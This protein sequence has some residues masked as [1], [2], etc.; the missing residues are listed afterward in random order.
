MVELR[1]ERL[2]LRMWRESDLRPWV[3]MNADPAVREHLPEVGPREPDLDSF[4]RFQGLLEHRNGY[5]LWVV[6]PVGGPSFAGVVGMDE[7][8]NGMPYSGMEATLAPARSWSTTAP[9]TT[10]NAVPTR[11]SPTVAASSNTTARHVT[12]RSRHGRR[13][14]SRSPVSMSTG[15]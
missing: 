2:S 3:A 4:D 11:A 8:G 15:A 6:E 12:S 7:A 10:T 14:W 9:G 13:L 1:T 5:G